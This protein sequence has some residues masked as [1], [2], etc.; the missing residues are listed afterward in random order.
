MKYLSLVIISTFIVGCF[1]SK[2]TVVDPEAPD[3]QEIVNNAVSK[4]PGYTLAEFNQ[5]E[6][7]YETK[8]TL[9]HTAKTPQNFTEEQWSKLVPGM[10]AKANNKKAAGLTK[11]DED[12]IYKYVVSI[13]L[14]DKK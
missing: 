3:P 8:C 14:N 9:C 13:M 11:A 5:G 10:A 12:L 6:S 1:A 4:F 7:L 2:S